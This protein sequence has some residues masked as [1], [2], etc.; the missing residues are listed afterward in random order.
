MSK[1]ITGGISKNSSGGWKVRNSTLSIDESVARQERAGNT[2]ILF[3]DLP[4]EMTREEIPVYLLTLPE[5]RDN[6]VYAEVLQSTI[7]KKLPKP[8]KAPK[9]VKV[10]KV[11]K[12]TK[13]K[14]SAVPGTTIVRMGKKVSVP[15]E[16]LVAA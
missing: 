7:A 10:A 16:D 15:A 2:D 1:F 3:V 5:F 6:A 13:P 12:V 14:V 11:A 8:A 9:A 4:T